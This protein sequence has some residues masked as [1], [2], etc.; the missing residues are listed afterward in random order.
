MIPRKTSQSPKPPK[1]PE[2]IVKTKAGYVFKP[3]GGI[4]SFF[5]SKLF[6]NTNENLTNRIKAL[7]RF[8]SKDIREINLS[9]KSKI[10]HR[11]ITEIVTGFAD[12]N[13]GIKLKIKDGEMLSENDIET[14]E[15]EVITKIITAKK[16]MVDQLFDESNYN[17]EFSYKFT[18]EE[19]TLALNEYLNENPNFVEDNMKDGSFD[20]GG[21]YKN[22]GPEKVFE[23][24]INKRKEADA[25][26]KPKT[27]KEEAK[28]S[29]NKIEI[30]P[31]KDKSKI[32]DKIKK[33]M[34]KLL[35]ENTHGILSELGV[36][37]ETGLNKYM[38]S[39][40]KFIEESTD[41]KG[42]LNQ[43][44]FEDHQEEIID[45]LR[46]DIVSKY[47]ELN[48]DKIKKEIESA[49]FKKIEAANKKKIDK[50][51][52]E[53][54]PWNRDF[55]YNPEGKKRDEEEYEEFK[56]NL[57]Q[58]NQLTKG[59]EEAIR[60]KVEKKLDSDFTKQVFNFKN[61]INYNV[62]KRAI[63]DAKDPEGAKLRNERARQFF[64][65]KKN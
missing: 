47:K 56:M 62:L 11:A 30:H 50:I 13:P 61:E 5:I 2:K 51:L 24:L 65:G 18:K 59:E 53:N 44:F 17:S 7:G 9:R 31:E 29:S 60:Q 15:K 42:D 55:R 46:D 32:E 1:L 27:T 38:E 57:G 52:L 63:E 16:D 23:N 3:S 54:N 39:H 6:G 4:K 8:I 64:K 48:K 34:V 41:K 40:P 37:L 43:D 19:I 35:E 28:I 20:S 10:D 22:K 26:E 21:F 12:K 36:N 14:I 45:L 49:F 25:I 58:N 33:E